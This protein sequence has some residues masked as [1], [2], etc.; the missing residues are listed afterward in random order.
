MKSR[1]N[2]TIA[3]GMR[4]NDNRIEQVNA[5]IAKIS[6]KDQ[7]ALM[8]KMIRNQPVETDSS[9]DKTSFFGQVTKILKDNWPQFLRGAGLTLLISITAQLQDSS[10]DS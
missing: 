3:I 5:A 4:K 1:K 2:A 6:A 7:T 8:D 9:Q 10:L